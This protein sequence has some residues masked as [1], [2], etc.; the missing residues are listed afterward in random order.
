VSRAIGG[1]RVRDEL[2]KVIPPRQ[3]AQYDP[4][5]ANQALD[6]LATR[7]NDLA[8]VSRAVLDVELEVGTNIIAHG[9]NRK[10]FSVRVQPATADASFAFGWDPSQPDNPAPSR[11]VHV[12]VVGTAMRARVVIE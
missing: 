10:P 12:T 2:A 3:G 4:A 7:I 5:R 9:L 6:A 8:D 11:N 1:R